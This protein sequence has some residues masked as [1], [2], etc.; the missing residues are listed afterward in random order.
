MWILLYSMYESIVFVIYGE[1][2][3]NAKLLKIIETAIVL[4]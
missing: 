3:R 1:E 2:L 4:P